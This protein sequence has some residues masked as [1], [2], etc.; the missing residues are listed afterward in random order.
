MAE[1][2]SFVCVDTHIFIIIITIFMHLSIDE[3]LGSF[4]IMTHVNSGATNIGLHIYFQ[5]SVFIFFR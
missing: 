4:Y 1:K 2:Y 5:T 3:H